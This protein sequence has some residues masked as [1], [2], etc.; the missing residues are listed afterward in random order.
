MSV[1]P[2]AETISPF[3]SGKQSR[4]SSA[5]PKTLSSS[6]SLEISGG[7]CSNTPDNLPAAPTA[8]NTTEVVA[9]E[10]AEIKYSTSTMKM[11]LPKSDKDAIATKTVAATTTTTIITHPD[12]AKLLVYPTVDSYLDAPRVPGQP[13]LS[14]KTPFD[15]HYIKGIAITAYDYQLVA[16]CR[17]KQHGGLHPHYSTVYPQHC[18]LLVIIV[19]I[20]LYCITQST[21]E[22]LMKGRLC[23]H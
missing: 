20:S 13:T 5:P 2:F 7:S 10:L 16:S 1:F 19:A 11:K 9:T 4:S 12:L 15:L 6:C 18:K 21:S 8:S 3:S 22:Y 14:T 17:L 23:S